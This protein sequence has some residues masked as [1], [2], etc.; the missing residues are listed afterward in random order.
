[1][2]WMAGRRRGGVIDPLSLSSLELYLRQDQVLGADGSAPA[3]WTNNRW[4]D[5]STHSRHATVGIHGSP[6]LR[7]TGANLTPNGSQ[8]VEFTGTQG[9]DVNFGAAISGTNGWTLIFYYKSITLSAGHNNDLFY[10]QPGKFLEVCAQSNIAFNGYDRDGKP[11]LDCTGVALKTFDPASS[12]GWHMLSYVFSPPVA[13]G[14]VRGYLD[15]TLMSPTFNNWDVALEGATSIGNSPGSNSAL[16][17]TLAVAVAFSE[18][19]SDTTRTG[20]E[21]YFHLRFD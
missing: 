5:L 18:A 19:F 10:A 3:A 17:G 15:G 7:T 21:A 1:M 4:T 11:G 2:L 14:V 6:H 8:V 9:L 16:E 12:T 20:V 13:T